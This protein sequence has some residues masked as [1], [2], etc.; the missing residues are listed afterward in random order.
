[1]FINKCCP[2]YSRKIGNN[3]CN[4]IDNENRNTPGKI[5]QVS[6]KVRQTKK[7]EKKRENEKVF[8]EIIAESARNPN[9]QKVLYAQRIKTINVVKEYLDRQMEKGF[10]RKDTDTEAIA[11]GF[12]ALYDGLIASEFLGVSEN[13]SK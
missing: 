4:Y 8:C 2:H 10:F 11:S 6:L 12:V 5:F 13:H 1:M 3:W 7:E 9:L